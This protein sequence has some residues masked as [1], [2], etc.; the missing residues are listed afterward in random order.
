MPIQIIACAG[1]R[2]PI[3]LRKG[4]GIVSASLKAA[5][6]LKGPALQFIKQSAKKKVKQILNKPIKLNK[7]DAKVKHNRKKVD[8]II[9]LNKVDRN[10][11]NLIWGQG[12]KLSKY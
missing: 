1:S 4:S 2:Q 12:L 7:F 5:R 8:Q 3:Y 9:K 6:S 11:S 10:P